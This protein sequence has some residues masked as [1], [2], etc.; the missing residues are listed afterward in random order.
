[1][2]DISGKSWALT[3]ETKE[4]SILIPDGG[5]DCL[6]KGVP[7]AVKKNPFGRLYVC[8]KKG[9]HDL[10][11]QLSDDGTEYVGLWKKGE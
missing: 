6:K 3:S 10:G 1:M 4:G 9:M 8:C 5:F 7:V 11:G 2:P